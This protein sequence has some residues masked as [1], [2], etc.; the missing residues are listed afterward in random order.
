MA[1][2]ILVALNVD[3]WRWPFILDDEVNILDLPGLLCTAVAANCYTRPSCYCRGPP[4]RW[5]P[6]P[7]AEV[8]APESILGGT[9]KLNRPQYILINKINN[10]MCSFFMTH[11]VF[12]NS[13]IHIDLFDISQGTQ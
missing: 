7:S 2:V 1:A 8:E 13:I 3:R 5:A 6:A 9:W 10:E 12:I 11:R 4:R